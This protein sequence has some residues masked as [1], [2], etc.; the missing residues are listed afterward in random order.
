MTYHCAP[1]LHK[2]TIVSTFQG[3]CLRR[4]EFPVSNDIVSCYDAVKQNKY[5]TPED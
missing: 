4:S 1:H 2:P 3:Y 5:Y